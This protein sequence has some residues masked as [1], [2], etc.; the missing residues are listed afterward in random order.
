MDVAGSTT[1]TQT[2]AMPCYGKKAP[3]SDRPRST[4]PKG[5]RLTSH[6]EQRGQRPT[7][8]AEQHGYRSS[9]DGNAAR[10]VDKATTQQ[11]QTNTQPAQAV[12]PSRT[13][14]VMLTESLVAP[15]PQRPWCAP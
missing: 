9:G 13:D 12:G 8:T 7:N 15:G 1:Q 2:P 5:R 6:T 11:R 14:G 4:D 10:M 3:S